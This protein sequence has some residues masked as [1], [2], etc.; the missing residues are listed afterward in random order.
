[1]PTVRQRVRVLAGGRVEITDPSLQEGAEV[2]VSVSV[3]E[4]SGDGAP[5]EAEVPADPDEGWDDGML[6]F[7]ELEALPP[8]PLDQILGAH[9]SGRTADEIDRDLRALRD[10]WDE[11][12]ARR[13]QRPS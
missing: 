7:E 1:M 9:P 6:T 8:L 5:A 10:E 3:P 4:P 2:E 12:F 11:P 13:E